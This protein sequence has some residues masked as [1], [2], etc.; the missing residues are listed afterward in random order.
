LFKELWGG[1]EGLGEPFGRG[2]MAGREVVRWG[3][4]PL[5]D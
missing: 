2:A 1:R 3:V 4:G 5:D